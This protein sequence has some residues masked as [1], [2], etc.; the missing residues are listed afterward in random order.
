MVKI[1]FKKLVNEAINALDTYYGPNPDSSYIYGAAVL[2]D[3]GNIYI[4]SNYA[5]DTASLTLHAEQVA[6]A[7]AASHKDAN[8]VAIASVSKEDPKGEKK[9]PPCGICK[10]LIW[11]NSKRSGLKVK[12]V[13]ANRKGKFTVKDIKKLEPYPWPD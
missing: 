6:L 3:K 8:I 5:S 4:G 1:D 10:Q 11:E 13:I 12:V 7:N 9:C 2:T